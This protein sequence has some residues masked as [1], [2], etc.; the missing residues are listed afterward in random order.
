MPIGT[1]KNILSSEK[2]LK[3]TT[4]RNYENKSEKKVVNNISSI[5]PAT[6]YHDS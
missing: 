1:I 5:A 3:I 6:G 2:Y 4:I